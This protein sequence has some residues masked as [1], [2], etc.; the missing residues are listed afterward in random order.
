MMRSRF[1]GTFLIVEGDTDQ[2]FYKKIVKDQVCRVKSADNK[3]NAIKVIEILNQTNFNGILSI[4]DADFDLLEGKIPYAPNI[5]FTDEHDM[6]TMIIKSPALE[7]FLTEYVY[8]NKLNYFLSSINKNLKDILLSKATEIGYLRWLSLRENWN[9]KF[10]NLDFLKFIDKDT[11]ELDLTKFYEA[12]INNTANCLLK[13]NFISKEIQKIQNSTN[14][15]WN[16]SSGHDLVKIL[17]IGL[18]FIF[19]FRIGGINEA[20]IEANLRLCYEFEFFLQTNLYSNVKSWEAS[21]T[22][23]LVFKN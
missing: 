2:R 12:V 16:V 20:K 1:M 4:I 8:E 9:L 22:P 10:K 14:D 15:S 13:A 11:L 7:K 21:N 23:Y 5:F 18:K 17:Y 6:E 19:G 3:G